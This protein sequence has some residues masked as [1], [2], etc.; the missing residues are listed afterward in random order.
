MHNVKD[1]QKIPEANTGTD[2]NL[3]VEKICTKMK[4]TASSKKENQDGMWR[5]YMLNDRKCKIL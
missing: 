3:L 1:V 2:Q 5:N 4:K